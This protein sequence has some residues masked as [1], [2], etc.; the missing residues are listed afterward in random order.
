MS[1]LPF[2]REFGNVFRHRIVDPD[3]ALLHQLHHRSGGGHDFGERSDVENRVH[4]HGLAA[5]FERAIA[6]GLA[7]DHL[8]VVPDQQHRAGNLM[9]VDGVED[10]GVEDAEVWSVGSSW[11][12]QPTQPTDKRLSRKHSRGKATRLQTASCDRLS[13]CF[14]FTQAARRLL[15]ELK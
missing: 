11:P 8:S 3:F 1:S 13:G 7:V 14:E 12:W 6:E 15:K 2:S 9:V 4:G 10:N 5:R